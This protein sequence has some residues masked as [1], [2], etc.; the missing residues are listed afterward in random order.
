MSDPLPTGAAQRPDAAPPVVSVIVPV[1][2]SERYVLETL[3]SVL[4]QSF[5]DFEV[6]IVD[7]GSPDRSIELCRTLDD[8]RIRYVHQSNAG[9]AA[10]RNAGMRRSR[11]RFLAF[12]DSD[13]R[14][15]PEKLARH[16]RH[17]EENHDLG[18]S[19]SYSVLI[20]EDG[21]PL[22]SYQTLGRRETSARQCFECNPVGNGSNAVV[23]REVFSEL[24]AG[25]DEELRQAEDFEFWVRVSTCTDWR[26]GCIPHPLTEYRIHSG[27]LSADVERQRSFHMQAISKIA[28]YAPGLVANHRRAAEANLHW[29]LARHLLLRHRLLP[30]ARTIGRALRLSPRVVRLHN[31]LLACSLITAMLVPRKVHRRMSRFAEH[32]YGS[33]QAARM[34]RRQ[35]TWG[36][37]PSEPLPR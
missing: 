4:D 30:A 17:F 9:L 2:R 37:V 7:D 22:G 20:G 10:A 21:S 18:I 3:R 33:L 5:Q 24:D 29:Y 35:R 14:W 13:D 6:V 34:R 11:G 23:R 25:F 32:T 12:V 8:P 28:D 1:Y 27:G 16:V 15:S 26:M 36:G 19:Y 31:L